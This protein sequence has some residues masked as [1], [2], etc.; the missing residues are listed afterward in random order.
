MREPL[1]S[2]TFRILSRLFGEAP[3]EGGTFSEW[4]TITDRALPISSENPAVPPHACETVLGTPVPEVIDGDVRGSA[5]TIRPP[6]ISSMLADVHGFGFPAS[7]GSD[8]RAGLE[9][10][11]RTQ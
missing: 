4:P 5:F 7:G 2:A 9:V 11:N 3:L 1:L 6:E 10:L 8:S